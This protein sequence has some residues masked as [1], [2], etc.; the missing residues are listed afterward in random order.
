MIIGIQAHADIGPSKGLEQYE[1][2]IDTENW[3]VESETGDRSIG[4]RMQG[5]TRRSGRSSRIFAAL[6]L[7]MDHVT[8]GPAYSMLSIVQLHN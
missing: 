1:D 3:P 2:C 8:K 4:A 7:G 6:T 5:G